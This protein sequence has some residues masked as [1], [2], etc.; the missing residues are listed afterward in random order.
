MSITTEA[1]R[2]RINRKLA[3]EGNR[4]GH[5]PDQGGYAIVE[6]ETNAIV[7]HF[8]DLEDIGRDLGVLKESEAQSN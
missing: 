4:L 3:H 1:L 6:L 7:S 8:M 2:K 5:F